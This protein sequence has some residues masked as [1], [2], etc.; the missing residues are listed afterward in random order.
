MIQKVL[1]SKTKWVT[2]FGKSWDLHT[3]EILK[4]SDSAALGLIQK[5]IEFLVKNKRKV[6][7]DAEHFFDGFRANP[8]F[9]LDCLRTAAKSGAA[10]LS[11]CDTNGGTLPGEI[12]EIFRAVKAEISAPLGIHAHNDSGVAVANSLVALAEGAALAQGTFAD[13][14][15]ARGTPISAR[16]S[17]ISK[18]KK[19]ANCRAGKIKKTDRAH[20]FHFRNRESPRAKNLPFVGANSFTHKGG[21]H[22]SRGA[23]KS[24][25]LRAHFAGVGREFFA[26]HDF[27]NCPG[28]RMSS[29][30]RGGSASN[31]RRRIRGRG[32]FSRG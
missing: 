12:R 18:L 28:S 30:S 20:E 27:P 15:S 7:F 22:A 9:A 31:C 11:L 5:T 29:R 14:G 3:R 23:Q 13:S 25:K 1:E 4:I 6:I 10:N 8:Q 32:R 24:E 17:R 26:N 19:I 21:I 16:S 2:V